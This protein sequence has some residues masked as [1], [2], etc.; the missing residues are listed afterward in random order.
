[1]TLW[2][3][4]HQAPLSMGFPRKNIVVGC[5][6]LL[7]KIFPTQGSKPGLLHCRQILYWLSH[8]GSPWFLG[9]R[10]R[11]QE[12]CI[13]HGFLEGL[14]TKGFGIEDAP[15]SSWSWR[16]YGLGRGRNG[17]ETGNSKCHRGL[18]GALWTRG[19][20]T[21]WNKGMGRQI[22]EARVISKEKC[23]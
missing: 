12:F 8:Q 2:T 17:Q 23:L 4:A 14:C 19:C 11:I 15:I 3:I 5:H 10:F 1:M 18:W 9:Y 6:F 13:V 16:D 7:Q 20:N 22:V 21:Q